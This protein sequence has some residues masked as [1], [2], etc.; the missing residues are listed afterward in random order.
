MRATRLREIIDR[1]ILGG[2]VYVGS[3]L[4]AAAHFAVGLVFWLLGS[5]VTRSGVPAWT[6]LLTLACV[7][8]A[9]LFRR[10]RPWL[11][12]LLGTLALAADG[13]LFGPST[14]VFISY[15]DVLYGIGAFGR[16][17]MAL[18][19]LYVVLAGHV[20]VLA[21]LVYLLATGGLPGGMLDLLQ[22]LGLA[23][24]LFLVPLTSGF[25]VREYR[26]R[27]ELERERAQQ[28]ARMAELDRSSAIAAERGRVAREL[29]DVIANH[30]SAVAVQSTAALSMREFDP[31]RVRRILEVVRDNSVQGLAEM[32]QMIGVLR[33]A[34]APALERVMPRLADAERLVDVAREAGLE[35][36][37]TE[38]GSASPL[39]AQVDAAGYR[40]VQESLTNALRYA[41][42]KRV[43]VTVE[44]RES[45]PGLRLL[46][47]TAE[48]AMPP[49]SGA[50]AA[51]ELG[52]GAGLTG[53][54]ERVAL[55][56]GTF[57]AGPADGGRW[58]VRAEV[59]VGAGT[60][61]GVGAS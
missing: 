21:V 49:G 55:L 13:A 1:R 23:A 32:R 34:D 30:L 2:S 25:T 22:L 17:R 31:E 59:P 58:R 28:V 36:D 33:A 16:R 47:I 20:V 19:T 29:H 46:V 57:A 60:G 61:T 11:A 4:W 48:N 10:S 53:M 26:M 50:E 27:A 24:V 6:L 40:I 41:E 38:R 56:G 54:R 8:V 7:C 52:G 45:G 37:Y 5:Y 42:P 44:R 3:A 39:P 51:A 35:V 15:G 18:W 14:W 9:L 43:R 12:L